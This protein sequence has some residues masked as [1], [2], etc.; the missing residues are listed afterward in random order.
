MKVI[1]LTGGVGSGKSFVAHALQEMYH[2]DL[3]LADELGHLVME[4]GKKG[5]ERI[6]ERFGEGILDEDG[7]IRREILAEIVFRDEDA[8][9]DLNGIVHPEVLEHI[10]DY[11]SRKNQKQGVILLE[12]AILFES[13]LDEFC[14]EIW[15]VFVPE[16]IRRKRLLDNRG[17]SEEKSRSIMRKQRDS[18]YFRCHCHKEIPNDGTKESVLET[19]RSLAKS[20]E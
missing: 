18:Q 3:L 20:F 1:G 13:H 11:I 2:C 17:Y 15:Y 5:Y 9:E 19:L 10:R 12:S 7:T 4:P 6:L 16:E 8:M 14:D